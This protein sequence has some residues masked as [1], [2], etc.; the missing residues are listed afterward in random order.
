MYSRGLQCL[1]ELIRNPQTVKSDHTLGAAVMLAIYEMLD[2]TS[3][4]SWLTHSRGITALFRHRG[5]EA[6]THGVGRMLLIAFRSFLVAD[7]LIR[8]EPCFL[9]EAEWRSII[10]SAVLQE[11]LLGKG[12]KIG[13]LIEYSFHEITI[14][15]GLVARL[16]SPNKPTH[17]TPIRMQKLIDEL[18]Q[19]R[20]SLAALHTQLLT[21]SSND[22]RL[23]DRPSVYGP[24]P[25]HVVNLLAD[26]SLRGIRLAIAFLD[27]LFLAIDSGPLQLTRSESVLLI[28]PKKGYR[29]TAISSTSETIPILAGGSMEQINEFPD[30]FVLSMG[31]LILGGGSEDQLS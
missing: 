24:I 12:S 4:C 25:D 27:R 31:M 14:I 9:E 15:P 28:E 1:A 17:C 26:F 10:N 11:W 16:L 5:A 20:E 18:T 7:A 3:Q 29:G 6:H 23:E 8:N 30:Q 13:D 21:L 2:G 22:I 19:S